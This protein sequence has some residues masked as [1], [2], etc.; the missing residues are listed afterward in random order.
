MDGMNAAGVEEDSLR[1]GGLPRVDVG[2]DADVADVR[3]LIPVV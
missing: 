3:K 2:G 1:Q